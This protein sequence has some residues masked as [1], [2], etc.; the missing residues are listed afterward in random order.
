MIAGVIG[1]TTVGGINDAFRSAIH[2]RLIQMY[3]MFDILFP[4]RQELLV[5]AKGLAFVTFKRHEVIF[6]DLIP[7]SKRI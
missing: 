7:D 6:F 1:V 4:L 5:I 2:A 3:V